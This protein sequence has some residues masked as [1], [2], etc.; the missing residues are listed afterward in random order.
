MERLAY[1]PRYAFPS[2]PCPNDFLPKNPRIDYSKEKNEWA[3]WI[4]K[5]DE[6]ASA[7]NAYQDTCAQF[8]GHEQNAEVARA[9]GTTGQVSSDAAKA[10]R[11]QT[12]KLKAALDEA[13]ENLKKN[14]P[15]TSSL[16]QFLDTYKGCAEQL[17][18][19]KRG[20]NA[21]RDD[22]VEKVRLSA[23]ACIQRQINQQ[24][25]KQRNQQKR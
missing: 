22:L 17:E 18:S 21:M 16:Q 20:V 13:R 8:T 25:F 10:F 4:G 1:F 19:K 7:V 15:K 2:R 5:S 6:V 14:Q 9:I 11:E 12:E 24:E 3:D 23:Q